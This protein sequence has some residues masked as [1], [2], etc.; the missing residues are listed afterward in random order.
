VLAEPD[1]PEEPAP[2]AVQPIR[3][4]R[5]VI[6]RGI[7]RIVGGEEFFDTEP[8]VA[9]SVPQPESP[10]VAK[11]AQAEIVIGFWV[12]RTGAVSDARIE[13]S[14]VDGRVPASAFEA[15]A[16]AAARQARFRPARR[17]GAPV[18]SWNTLTYSFSV[19]E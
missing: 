11:G 2:P 9:L 4:A 19:S 6:P 14:H 15:A 13:L 3:K 10:R 17:K 5:P 1:E 7:S 16:L 8:A 18:D 12:D